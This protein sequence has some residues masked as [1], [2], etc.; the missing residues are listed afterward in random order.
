MKQAELDLWHLGNRRRTP[1]INDLISVWASL[2]GDDEDMVAK[3][4]RKVLWKNVEH[5]I[6]IQTSE[7]GSDEDPCPQL[8]VD[9]L[10]RSSLNDRTCKIHLDGLL[11]LCDYKGVSYPPGLLRPKPK[12]VKKEHVKATKVSNRYMQLAIEINAYMWGTEEA[13]MFESIGEP[14]RRD[15]IKHRFLEQKVVSGKRVEFIK[16]TELEVSV[17]KF[18]ALYY[19]SLPEKKLTKGKKG[20]KKNS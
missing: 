11:D 15:E 12:K 14:R 13:A 5:V 20:P 2:S 3:L 9:L 1:Y 18:D 19:I 4:I 17:R 7:E 8:T 16:G 6:H 10:R